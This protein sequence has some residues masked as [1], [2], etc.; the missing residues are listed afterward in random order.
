MF[1]V[2]VLAVFVAAIVYTVISARIAVERDA[3]FAARIR[4]TDD[5]E[6]EVAE[7]AV[8]IELASVVDAAGRRL[9]AEQLA[10]DARLA[11]SANVLTQR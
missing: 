4:A 5:N 1:T 2:A 9:Q 7:R 3:A 11:P 10:L 8:Q 6:I